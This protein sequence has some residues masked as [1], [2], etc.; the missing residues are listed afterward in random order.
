MLCYMLANRTP[1]KE[2]TKKTHKIIVKLCCI[3]VSCFLSDGLGILKQL[4]EITGDNK[5]GKS[6]FSNVAFL[7]HLVLAWRD[8]GGE[9]NGRRKGVMTVYPEV[10]SLPGNK[11]CL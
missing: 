8:L 11:A 2:Y 5:W 3:I 4:D 1:I 10:F 9:G 6:L 7:T